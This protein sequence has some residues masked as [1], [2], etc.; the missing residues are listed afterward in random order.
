[1]AHARIAFGGFLYGGLKI[2]FAV[3]LELSHSGEWHVSVRQDAR[4]AMAMR[5]RQQRNPTGKLTLA[6]RSNF[7]ADW[8]LEGREGSDE[9]ADDEG[10]AS[11]LLKSKRS[12]YAK[13]VRDEVEL[14]VNGRNN[15]VFG[16]ALCRVQ[17]F[18]S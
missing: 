6:E 8:A 4:N 7:E 11:S 17:L 15:L 2:Q 18:V 5:R 14:S 10:F 13:A 16:G 1:M 12:R 3:A 9:G